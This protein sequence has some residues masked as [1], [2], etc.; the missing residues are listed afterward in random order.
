LKAAPSCRRTSGQSDGQRLPISKG[1]SLLQIDQHGD[2]GSRE[3]R[4]D[5]AGRDPEHDGGGTVKAGPAGVVPVAA[6]ADRK[7]MW[8]VGKTGGHVK[9]VWQAFVLNMLMSCWK[10]LTQITSQR[11]QCRLASGLR[12]RRLNSKRLACAGERGHSTAVHDASPDAEPVR[13]N[14]GKGGHA[15][16]G[17]PSGSNHRGPEGRTRHSQA[18]KEAILVRRLQRS[19]KTTCSSRKEVDKALRSLLPNLVLEQTRV[20]LYCHHFNGLKKRRGLCLTIH[21][22]M[23]FL[24]SMSTIQIRTSRRSC[25][26]FNMCE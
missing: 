6:A 5:D 8:A 14:D 1:D 21:L 26:T 22:L 13:N 25:Q 17:W 7:R 12:K 10:S 15:R 19:K 24:S 23:A 9:V 4:K 11:G 2:P 20:T 3:E 16:D 18:E